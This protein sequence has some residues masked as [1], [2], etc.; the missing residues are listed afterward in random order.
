MGTVYP[1]MAAVRSVEQSFCNP[2]EREKKGYAA[3]AFI[4]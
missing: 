3:E 4:R 1:R 2:N